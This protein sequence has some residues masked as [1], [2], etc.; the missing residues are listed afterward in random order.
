MKY[1]AVIFDLFGTLVNIFSRQEYEKVIGEMA[2][3]LQVPCDEFY[4]LWMQTASQRAVGA[5]PTLEENLKHICVELNIPVTDD[6]LTS[7]S[8]ARFDY[9]ARSLVP[10]PDAIPVLSELRSRG[11]R[12]ALV[13]NCS[14]EPPVIWR[15][16]PFAPLMDAAV[17][18]STA[19]LQKPDPRIYQMAL[20]QLAVKPDSCLYIGDGDNQELSG[21]AAVGL[22]PVLIREPGEDGNAVMR[23][24]DEINTWQGS[25]ISSLK[26]ILSLLE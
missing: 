22:H 11:C 23:S 5:F 26:E 7:A 20:R 10:K 14:Q 9:V 1:Q 8:R 3:I 18:S 24:N 17:F 12:T 13:S 16:T 4:R 21:A 2:S 19:G 6:R 15:Q 25:V